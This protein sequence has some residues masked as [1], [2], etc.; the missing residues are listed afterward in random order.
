[1][2]GQTSLRLAATHTTMFLFSLAVGCLVTTGSTC[3]QNPAGS[4][5]DCKV[6]VAWSGQQASHWQI[7][8]S[9]LDESPAS[10]ISRVTNRC[11]NSA[12]TGA[13]H[14]SQNSRTLTVAP[15][16]VLTD[17]EFDLKLNCS[18]DATLQVQV[19]SLPRFTKALEPTNNHWQLKTDRLAITEILSGKP[20]TVEP[21]AGADQVT[22]KA[23]ITRVASDALR[24]SGFHDPPLYDSSER[25]QFTAHVNAL[26]Q[27]SSAE[28]MLA[29]EIREAVSGKVVASHESPIRTNVAGNADPVSVDVACPS[30]PGVYQVRCFIREANE[31]AFLLLSRK[32]E[33]L[34]SRDQPLIVLAESTSDS[35]P[36]SQVGLIQPGKNSDWQISNWLPGTSKK[37]LRRID[38]YHAQE[39][40]KSK[41]QG[42]SLVRLRPS[43]SYS[44]PVPSNT[45][46]LPHK[47]TLRFK[48]ASQSSVR[49]EVSHNEKFNQIS[50]SFTLVGEDQAIDASDWMTQTFVHYP[51]GDDDFLRVTNTHPSADF[52]LESIT[53]EAG[54]SAL[55]QREND[56]VKPVRTAVLS[57]PNHEWVHSLSSD[58]NLDDAFGQVSVD[59]FRFHVAAQRVCDYANASGYTAIKIPAL[60]GARAWFETNTFLPNRK[61]SELDQHALVVLAK[62]CE[63]NEIKLFVGINPQVQLTSPEAILFV[64]ETPTAFFRKRG[65]RQTLYNL[66]HPVIQKSLQE[67][68]RDIES[69]LSSQP[70]FAGLVLQC[71]SRNHLAPLDVQ[72][73]TPELLADFAVAAGR[74]AEPLASVANWARTEGSAAVRNWMRLQSD[75]IYQRIVE[76]SNKQ[77]LFLIEQSGVD[78]S[79]T[80][81]GRNPTIQD[82][83]RVSNH[84]ISHVNRAALHAEPTERQAVAVAV[85]GRFDQGSHGYPS[86]LQL[87]G[88]ELSDVTIGLNPEVLM[89]EDPSS[90]FELSSDVQSKLMNFTAMPSK[91]FVELPNA[92]DTEKTVRVRFVRRDNVGVLSIVNLAPWTSDVRIECTEAL[93]WTPLGGLP[94]EATWSVDGA[95]ILAKLPANKTLTFSTKSNMGGMPIAQWQSQISGGAAAAKE[96]KDKVTKVVERIG[97]LSDPLS[98]QQLSNG[99]FEKNGGVGIVGWMHTQHP[100]GAVIVVQNESTDG[101]SSVLL[102]NSNLQTGRAWLVSEN[103]PTPSSGRLAVSLACRGDNQAD[104]E[105]LQ[106]RVSIEGIRDGQSFRHSRQLEIPRNGQWQPRK[107]VLELAELNR[108]Q[109]PSVRLTLDS[110]SEG[111][112]W[113]DDVR[114][115]DWFATSS[116]RDVLQ[117]DTFLAVKGIQHGDLTRAAR[118]LHN[119]WAGFL[120]RLNEPS[121]K[122]PDRKVSE[123]EKS[124]MGVGD[125]IKGWIPQPLRF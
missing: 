2:A 16:E 70:S 97:L 121:V 93:A 94:S 58:F 91:G 46:H 77:T 89:V 62:I 122:V 41:F 73:L 53:V 37:I 5:V 47:V 119:Y 11:D 116:E 112:T 14:L 65:L 76:R 61:S 27:K 86:R 115:H 39:F 10:K 71:S 55:A 96:V 57:L 105:P 111:K 8:V 84:Q 38:L 36:W 30:R 25:V 45:A 82:K 35:E 74:Q 12:A 43:R 18:A 4:S 49:V 42:Q 34:V 64:G 118:L 99:S 75:Q 68:T 44:T 106:L 88:A 85:G 23:T 40:E 21:V 54:P 83:R 78:L 95:I 3:A 125:R 48:T 17:G 9:L 90:A 33:L 50:R 108:D 104:K 102:S 92:G 123:N 113:I 98:Y 124:A 117:N 80:S 72:D 28:L 56:A 1:M 15:R 20:I 29:Y 109:V 24:L 19:V 81:N 110:L 120:V 32:G 6:R 22:A 66:R 100:Q 60:Q 87:T 52:E 31:K 114:I 103:I 101:N 107:I 79:A 51:S 26:T 59:A 7:R 13:Y 67:M 69:Q 63:L